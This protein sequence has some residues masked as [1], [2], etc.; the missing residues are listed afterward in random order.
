VKLQQLENA[1]IC[2]LCPSSAHFSILSGCPGLH[3][4][5]KHN[6]ISFASNSFLSTDSGFQ[7][8]ECPKGLHSPPVIL[9]WPTPAG[10]GSLN[11]SCGHGMSPAESRGG[12]SSWGLC[13][14]CVGSSS[15][16]WHS[17]TVLLLGKENKLNPTAPQGCG[18]NPGAWEGT[19]LQSG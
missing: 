9:A 13:S 10:A 1:V 8:Q 4:P 14:Q 15:L 3:L 16:R 5:V 18:G 17:S 2:L 6:I 19:H 12:G 11:A 7:Y